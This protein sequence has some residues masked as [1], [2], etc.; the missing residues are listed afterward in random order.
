[1]HHA[2]SKYIQSGSFSFKKLLD[3]TPIFQD[4]VRLQTAPTGMVA[5]NLSKKRK[6]K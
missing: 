2:P 5:Q 3:F 4:P 1:M 6:T